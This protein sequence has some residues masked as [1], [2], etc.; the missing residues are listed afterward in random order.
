M[1]EEFR[2]WMTREEAASPSPSSPENA[3]LSALSSSWDG[4]TITKGSWTTKGSTTAAGGG[5]RTTEGAWG[6]SPGRGSPPSPPSR[7]WKGSGRSFG[8]IAVHC[9]RKPATQGESVR[10]GARRHHG[11][12]EWSE[13]REKERK[14]RS[15]CP[16]VPLSIPGSLSLPSRKP[17]KGDSRN[18]LRAS[19]AE[20]SGKKKNDRGKR[21]SANSSRELMSDCVEDG[22]VF[23]DH[24]S[25]MPYRED[26]Q[27]TGPDNSH[28][29]SRR[30]KITKRKEK[31]LQGPR[32]TSGRRILLSPPPAC[33]AFS[34]VIIQRLPQL[35]TVKTCRTILSPGEQRRKKPGGRKL[36]KRGEGKKKKREEIFFR[37]FSRPPLNLPSF[38][39]LSKSSDQIQRNIKPLLSRDEWCSLLAS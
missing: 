21:H 38:R 22:R 10:H 2:W 30:E 8:S 18:R 32:N 35:S 24:S 3:S 37:D 34:S 9:D 6:V 17:R 33:S 14:R 7:G 23:P 5:G 25:Q 12:F 27:I 28:K 16:L 36:R 1:K 13:T 19:D 39:K 20:V 29:I 26:T 15:K 11:S 4:G 31:K